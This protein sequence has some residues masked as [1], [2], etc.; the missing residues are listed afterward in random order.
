MSGL[1]KKYGLDIIYEDNHIVVVNKK[2]SQ[3]VQGDKTGDVPMSDI[4][5]AYLKEKYN[6]PGNVYLGLV[7]RLDRPT[8]G[9]VIFGR[10]DKAASRLS[11]LFHDRDV[12]KKYWAVVQEAPPEESG[13]LIHFLRKKEKQNK[14][15]VV[16]E[17]A[18]GA[19]K[20]ELKYKLLGKSDRYYLLE[21]ELLSGRHHQI[22]CQ[23]AHI[24]CPIKGDV[25]YGFSRANKDLSI[26]LHARSLS[27]VHP[28]KKEQM[29]YIAKPPIDPVWNYFADTINDNL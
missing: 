21:V 12:A 6:K 5:K 8:S 10:T 22:R 25:K 3:I 20:A 13:H 24:G 29:Q 16:K 1:Q 27:L 7:H 9:I 28:V 17:Q 15:Y 14:S 2:P 18:E 11:K 19:K 4:L 23:L 26:H